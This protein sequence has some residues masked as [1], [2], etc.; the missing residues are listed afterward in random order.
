MTSEEKR[1]FLVL[2]LVV[3]AMGI[4]GAYEN[5][6]PD[7]PAPAVKPNQAQFGVTLGQVVARGEELAEQERRR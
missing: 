1:A 4:C 5:Y 7:T 6:V 2:I 3:V